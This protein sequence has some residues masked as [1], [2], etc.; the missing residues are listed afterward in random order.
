MK[1]TQ[2]IFENVLSSLQIHT[3]APVLLA[4]SGGVDSVVLAHLLCSLNYRV[5][6]AHVNYGLRGDQ[7][8]ADEDFVVKLA[9][10]LGAKSHVLRV[11]ADE[12]FGNDKTGIQAKARE[13][14]YNWLKELRIRIKAQAILVAHH[15]NDQAETLVHRFV[16]G[17]GLRSLN[18][19][20]P[21]RDG[22]V[23][24]LLGFSKQE[25]EEFATANGIEWRHD[26][27]NDEN[28]YTRN[29]IRNEI[30]PMLKLINP[31]LEKV[32][33][34]RSMMVSRF[35]RYASEKL[36]HDLKEMTVDSTGLRL[37][38]T[39]LKKHG[40]PDLLLW[41]W[42]EPRGM[43]ASAI[44]E[45]LKLMNAHT[46]SHRV[47]DTWL[48][49]KE[50]DA[51]VLQQKT[52][53]SENRILLINEP[54]IVPEFPGLAFSMVE[55][56]EIDFR[57]SNQKMFIDESKISWPLEIRSWQVG[58]R[59]VPLGMEHEQKLSDFFTHNKIPV[60]E[61]TKYPVILSA[62]KIIAIAGLRPSES[63]RITDE[64]QRFLKIEFAH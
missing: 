37:S 61:R 17:G 5:H 55:S 11:D 41:Q 43:P 12:A 16:R 30:M 64:T 48:L 2:E 23:R 52:D 60:R 28:Y 34:D 32:L 26:Q 53:N 22:V 33:I 29:K 25:I 18:A 62:G 56:D 4:I 8:K 21:N 14:R 47:F 39:A 24:P 38:L 3:E 58:D 50:S 45:V 19:M 46:G 42:L 10:K 49:W 15:L 63:V 35:E 13:I 27:S 54:C 40:F 7:S 36:K 20:M 9:K 44:P 1:L 51:L 31:H 6:F 59:F 57:R